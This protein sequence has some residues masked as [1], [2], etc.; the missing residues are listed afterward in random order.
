MSSVGPLTSES[1]VRRKIS[2]CGTTGHLREKEKRIGD[3]V[4]CERFLLVG[5]RNF[6]SGTEV[7]T[8]VEFPGCDRPIICVQ[9]LD[10]LSSYWVSPLNVGSDIR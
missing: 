2:E 3:R 6:E 7:G 1:E 5:E 4:Y 9:L 8:D 10:I